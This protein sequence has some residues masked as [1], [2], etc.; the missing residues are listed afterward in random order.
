[1]QVLSFTPSD[2]E[3]V[4]D[5]LIDGQP[6]LDLLGDGEDSLMGIPYHCL[7]NGLPTRIFDGDEY[8]LVAVCSCGVES[9]GSLEAKLTTSDDTVRCDFGSPDQ[10][11]VFSRANLESVNKLLSEA[12]RAYIQ[13][14][15]ELEPAHHAHNVVVLN[16]YLDA[17]EIVLALPNAQTSLCNFS[18]KSEPSADDVARWLEDGAQRLAVGARVSKE[19]ECFTHPL[20]G[21]RPMTHYV[22]TLPFNRPN[23]IRVRANADGRHILCQ[24]YLLGGVV[25]ERNLSISTICRH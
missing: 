10:V 7:D 13:R 21:S 6:V 9:C 24:G 4:F 19:L 15:A 5:I 25:C 17:I 2:H 12:A 1:M 3:G 22:S 23:G 14:L 20:K 8:L 16:A 11:F 18:K